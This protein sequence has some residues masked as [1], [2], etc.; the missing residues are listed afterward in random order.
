MQQ[1]PRQ[2]HCLPRGARGAPVLV[3]MFSGC[4]VDP[5]AP[6]CTG[7]RLLTLY[8]RLRGRDG[9]MHVGLAMGVVDAAGA[10]SLEGWEFGANAG[11]ASGMCPL[12]VRAPGDPAAPP[13]RLAVRSAMYLRVSSAFAHEFLDNFCSAGAS[14]F[15]PVPLRYPGLPRAGV[16]YPSLRRIVRQACANLLPCAAALAAARPSARGP[17]AGALLGAGGQFP[18]VDE[19][20]RSFHAEAQCAQFAMLPLLSLVG[21]Q[22][23]ECTEQLSF[24]EQARIREAARGDV[25][26][27]P[28]TVLALLRAMPAFARLAGGDV[29]A[30]DGSAVP[31]AS[32]EVD[33]GNF[34]RV[35]P[36]LARWQRFRLAL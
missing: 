21:A 2:E 1:Q 27:H 25:G 24:A 14:P 9:S 29:V 4:D 33:N 5:A 10:V 36:D 35:L 6:D 22:A 34:G 19:R 17:G 23:P 11:R 8:E 32:V 30:L 12:L 7:A 13:V 18:D 20:L 15:A 3:W 31:L 26:L 28:H 16:P